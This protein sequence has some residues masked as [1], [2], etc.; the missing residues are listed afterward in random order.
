MSGFNLD[1]YKEMLAGIELLQRNVGCK[2]EKQDAVTRG[3]FNSIIIL[4]FPHNNCKKFLAG[5]NAS[6][7]FC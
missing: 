6:K 3:L 7:H 4:F 2:I 5:F 1:D